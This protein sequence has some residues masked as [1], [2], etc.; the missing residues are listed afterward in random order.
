MTT[1]A[2]ILRAAAAG[3]T[4]PGP[5]FLGSWLESCA[6]SWL[7]VHEMLDDCS[8]GAEGG[9]LRGLTDCERRAFLILIAETLDKPQEP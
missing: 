9:L 1:T 2:D 3:P 5:D 6:I 4:P 8:V 7:C